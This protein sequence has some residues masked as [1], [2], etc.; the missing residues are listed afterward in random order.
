[1]KKKLYVVGEEHLKEALSQV[2]NWGGEVF[3]SCL[4][5]V[6]NHL[7]KSEISL[8]GS[9]GFDWYPRKT[10]RDASIYLYN[11]SADEDYSRPVGDV[12]RIAIEDICHVEQGNEEAMIRLLLLT[13]VA[14]VLRDAFLE[15]LCDTER[16]SAQ[17]LFE[18]AQ[19]QEGL[20]DELDL[21]NIQDRIDRL[22]KIFK[23]REST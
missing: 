8:P 10:G 17:S 13:E 6:T 22:G 16:H 21:K 9:V 3:E 7:Q 20:K 1:M 4:S 23:Q 15:G 5:A 19:K 2:L 14:D 18:W 12:I 11:D